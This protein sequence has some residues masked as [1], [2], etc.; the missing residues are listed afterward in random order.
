MIKVHRLNGQEILINAELI[1]AVEAIPDTSIVLYTG[2]RYVVK[3][4]CDD[5]LESV[6]EYKRKA[7]STEPKT[8]KKQG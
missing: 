8:R 4:S 7:S 5:V 3:E 6:L 1:E 2:N